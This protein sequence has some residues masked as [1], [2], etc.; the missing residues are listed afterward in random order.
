MLEVSLT[1]LTGFVTLTVYII[2]VFLFASYSHIVRVLSVR[3][4]QPSMSW[5]SESVSCLSI[6]AASSKSWVTIKI[7]V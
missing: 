1:A 7:A 3:F 2:C 6:L 5:P 4:F